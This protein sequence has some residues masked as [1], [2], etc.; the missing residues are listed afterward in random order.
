MLLKRG[1]GRRAVFVFLR[2]TTAAAGGPPPL[3]LVPALAAV[4]SPSVVDVLIAAL[5]RRARR[6]G[7]TTSGPAVD[8]GDDSD[9]D[10]DAQVR[11]IV[12]V[13]V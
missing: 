11:R 3:V 13:V 10:G 12:R 1:D 8:C 5:S 6:A 4:E 9:G 7:R 2:A